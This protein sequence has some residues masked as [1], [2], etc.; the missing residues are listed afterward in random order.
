LGTT[1]FSHE[2]YGKTGPVKLSFSVM[3]P[4]GHPIAVHSEEWANEIFKRTNGRVKVTVFESGSLT[5]PDKSYD[6]V[7]KGI[8]AIGASAMGYTRGRFPLTEVT[9]LPFGYTTGLIATKTVNAFYKKFKPKEF[10]NVKVLYFHAHGPGILH[11][12]KPVTKLED[13]KAMKIRSTGLSAKIVEALGAVPVAMHMNDTYDALRKGVVDGSFA[14]IASLWG[15][16][17]GE[18]IKYSIEDFGYAYTTGFFVVM[19]KAKW[20][21]LPADVQKIIESI[22]EEFIPKGGKAWDDYDKLGRDYTLKLGNKITQLTKEESERWAKAVRITLDDYVKD[23]NKKN[24]P[25]DEAL[26]FC[27]DYLKKNQ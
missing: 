4:V 17:W 25:G 1:G 19:N 24:L 7:V 18:L 27:F 14:P 12:K 6:G 23:M 10:D 8:S 21:A 16:K 3:W 5:S 26:K 15:N 11:T 2:V 22:N 9:D 13:L 20:N